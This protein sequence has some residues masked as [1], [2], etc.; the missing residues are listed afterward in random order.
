MMKKKNILIMFVLM[1][2]VCVF[3]LSGCGSKKLVQ[4]VQ[5]NLAE[6]RYNLMLGSNSNITSSLMSG[7]REKDYVVNGIATESVDFGVLTFKVLN[8][9]VVFTDDVKYV[10]TV[11]TNR[12][13][14]IL[15]KNPFDGSYVA[16][17]GKII[18]DTSEVI[19]AKILCGTFNEEVELISVTKD[20]KV[21]HDNALK[22]ACTELKR[23]LESFF[24]N[25]MFMGEAYVK[26]IN[27]ELGDKNNY[28]WYVS[29]VNRNG[30]NFAVIIDPKTNEILAK[31]NI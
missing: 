29:F 31:K 14:G 12:T 30:K 4:I 25:D 16:D 26:I 13:D 27:D 6:V 18:A 15:E 10:L 2:M 19:K 3:T 11:G 7:K 8:E 9:D 23:E 21:Q 28:Y 5:S 17:I 22:L 1:A 20:W 24:E